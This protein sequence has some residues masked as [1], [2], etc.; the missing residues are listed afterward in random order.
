MKVNFNVTFQ[1][2]HEEEFDCSKWAME[3]YI[4]E[5]IEKELKERLNMATHA[6]VNNITCFI[7]SNYVEID[8]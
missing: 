6:N 3:Y 5:C 1:I 8:D 7:T 4:K 2:Q